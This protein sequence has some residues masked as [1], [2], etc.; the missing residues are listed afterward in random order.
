MTLHISSAYNE[1]LVH[2]NAKVVEM[3]GLCEQMIEHSNKAVRDNNIELADKV[4]LLDEKTD[5]LETDINESIIRAI[6]L[7]QPVAD[8]LRVLFSAIKISGAFERVGDLCKNIAKRTRLLNDD[9]HKDVRKSI[10]SL[11]EKVK[12]QLTRSINSY[13][14]QDIKLAKKVWERDYEIDRLYTDL[15]DELLVYL[16][17]K[18]R[19]AAG[20]HLMIIAKNYER[21]GDH[22]THISEMTHFAITGRHLVAERPKV[23]LPV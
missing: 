15:F 5:D 13:T 21:I 10:F 11:G 3:G 2:I 16:K 9:P 14:Q 23:N 17:K 8:D 1:D 18:K 20:S 4:V 19:V 6:A 12:E 7:R 22:T